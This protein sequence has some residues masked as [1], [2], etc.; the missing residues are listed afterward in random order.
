MYYRDDKFVKKFGQNLRELRKARGISQEQLAFD[1]G[2][3]LS[4]IGRIERG[5]INTSISHVSA[6]SKALKI[7]PEELFRF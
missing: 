5:E 1:T 6:I 3:E 7:K 4:Q 2:F